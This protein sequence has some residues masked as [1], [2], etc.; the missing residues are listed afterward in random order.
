[1]GIK[2]NLT[3]FEA[4]WDIAK[5]NIYAVLMDG[6][7]LDEDGN[8]KDKFE[9]DPEWTDTIKNDSRFKYLYIKECD[10]L[11]S[12]SMTDAVNLS[13]DEIKDRFLYDSLPLLRKTMRNGSLTKGESVSD[14]ITDDYLDQI[15]CTAWKGDLM[16]LANSWDRE[17]EKERESE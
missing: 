2:Y 14:T 7:R 6:M 17:R 15:I 10:K 1:M 16:I 3:D 11:R 4:I 5:H 8:L 9:Y 13:V 12:M